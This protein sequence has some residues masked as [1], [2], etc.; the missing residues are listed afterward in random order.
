MEFEGLYSGFSAEF[1]EEIIDG[2]DELK[3]WIDAN[4]KP[5]AGGLYYIY[6]GDGEDDGQYELMTMFLEF[7]FEDYVWSFKYLKSTWQIAGM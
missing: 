7:G 2:N 1:Y 6:K 3:A 5:V 4:M